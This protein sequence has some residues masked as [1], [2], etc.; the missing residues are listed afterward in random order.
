MLLLDYPV[1]LTVPKHFSATPQRAIPSSD[2]LPRWSLLKNTT[3]KTMGS[4]KSSVAGTVTAIAVL[5]LAAWGMSKLVVIAAGLVVAAWGKS[6]LMVIAA[7]LVLAVWTIAKLIE[8]ERASRQKKRM[9]AATDAVM[10][11][12]AVAGLGLAAWGMSKLLESA[13]EDSDNRKTMKA[14]GREYKIYRDDFER[15]PASYFR[16][17]RK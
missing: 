6:K 11:I 13:P 8:R 5:G 15:D 9:D 7:G 12:G 16:S 3:E 1:R 4:E 14:P 17:L 10:A 2:L